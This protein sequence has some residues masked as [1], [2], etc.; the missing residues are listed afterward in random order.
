MKKNLAE[1][2]QRDGYVYLYEVEGNKGLVKIGYTSRSIG[3]RHEEWTFDCNRKVETIYPIHSGSARIVPNARRIEALCHAELCHHKIE[4]YFRG[5]LKQHLEWFRVS[6]EE[7]IAIIE[8]WSTW[9]RTHPY[10]STQELRSGAKWFLK[11]EEKRRASNMS[12][13]M[14]EISLPTRCLLES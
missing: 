2:D 9:M 11:D 6:H 14:K 1:I 13:F 5:C 7:A 3:K 12:Q 10:Q 4:I 8:K